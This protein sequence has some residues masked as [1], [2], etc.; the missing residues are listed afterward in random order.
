MRRT[1]TQRAVD[2]AL[3]DVCRQSDPVVPADET[4]GEDFLAGARYHRIAPLAHVALRE[5][6]PDLAAALRP[7]R[8]EALFH[9]LRVSAILGGV[10][11]SFG[12]IPW[13]VFKGPMLS[14]FAHPVPGLRFYKDLD[15]LVAP[16]DF[17]LAYHR[18]RD[19]GWQILVG[20][21]SLSGAELPGE[22]PLV[23]EHG[24]VMDLHWSMVVMKSVRG[25]FRIDAGPL[26]ER[27]I[28]VRLGPAAL[29]ALEPTDALVHVCHHAALAGATKLGHLLD[30]DQ[31]A[32]HV[33]DWDALA[34]RARDWTAE[35]Q[36]AVV[37]G[38]ARRRFDTPVP[39]GLDAMLG[40]PPRVG[41]VLAELDRAQPIEALRHDESWVRLV[42]RAL[43]PGLVRTSGE[44]LR[45]AG[46][47]VWVRLRPAPERP[48][49][50]AAPAVVE[51]FLARVEAAG[52]T[53]SG[54]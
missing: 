16:A 34:S 36:V 22:I 54:S 44:V 27:R 42:T 9:H 48:H 6:R 5:E 11:Q 8:D 18:L 51:A 47:G 2:R 12:E 31:L 10:A 40:V 39:A 13:L 29:A 21:E 32:R 26:L 37:L 28:P 15:V 3:V 38:R 35:V 46:K 50:P 43:R 33:D 1:T 24:V 41:R 23:S 45:R 30:A 53:T 52:R 4:S 20:D 17:R 25:R 14:E 49:G 7:D 19:A